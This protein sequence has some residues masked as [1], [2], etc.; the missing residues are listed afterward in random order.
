MLIFQ[1]LKFL[2]GI[3][4]SNRNKILKQAFVLGFI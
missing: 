2:Q 4:I 3:K 1:N